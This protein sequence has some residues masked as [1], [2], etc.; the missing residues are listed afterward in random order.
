MI[1]KAS[2]RGGGMA[3]AA[4]LL[5]PENEHVEVHE[6]RGF[7]A[8]DV[9]GAMKEAQAIAKGTRC[10]QHLFSVSLNPPDSASVS[11]TKFESAIERIEKANGLSGHPR[12]IIFH[13]K[14]GRRHAHCVWSRI[15]A[16]TMT[17]RPLPFFKTKLREISKGLYLEHA[18]QMPRGLMDSRQHDPRNFSLAEWQQAKRMGRDPRQLKALMQECWAVSDNRPA[19]EKALQER[20]LYF[21]K[22]DRR[23]HVAVTYEGEVVSIARMVGVKSKDVT[24]K[25]GKAD[26]LRSVADAKSHIASVVAPRLEALIN[27]ANL[28]KT[29]EMRPLE[30][31]R[32]LM[33]ERHSL[34]RQAMTEGQQ[35]RSEKETRIRAERFRKGVAGLWDRLTGKHSAAA[36]ENERE[37]FEAYKRDRAQ[38]D[39]LVSD[40][41]KE[42]LGLQ[43]EI[44]AVRGRHASRVL[45]L[46]RDVARLREGNEV[47]HGQSRGPDTSRSRGRSGPSLGI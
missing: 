24:A 22:G 14:E 20:G 13:E 42:R 44:L 9:K 31:R 29:R 30:D 12:I 35:L 38:R 34:E 36:K 45:D 37:T 18:W 26:D 3:L 17:A 47:Q 4:H 16:E 1:L 21:A 46:H 28:A 6:I 5:K 41:L 7:I 8:D 25:L 2:Q 43:R 23:A 19:F 40:Q 11:A 15:D 10:R 32:R 33:T 27:V 39:E